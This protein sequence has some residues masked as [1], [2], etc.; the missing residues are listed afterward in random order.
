V[1][2]LEFFREEKLELA[3]IEAVAE[4]SSYWDSASDFI[5]EN[6]NRETET[7]STKQLGWMEK[8]LEDMVE[9][10]IEGKL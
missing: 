8:I 4:L 1:K 9:L 7:F 5:V 3:D 6:W 10:R 2:V